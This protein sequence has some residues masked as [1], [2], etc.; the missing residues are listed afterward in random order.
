[1]CERSCASREATA[2]QSEGLQWN[3][4]Q[5]AAKSDPVVKHE[6]PNSDIRRGCELAGI[7]PEGMHVLWQQVTAAGEERFKNPAF[8]A[9]ESQYNQ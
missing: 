5:F 2:R 4:Q 7:E 1:M 3:R 9:D 6:M 8:V